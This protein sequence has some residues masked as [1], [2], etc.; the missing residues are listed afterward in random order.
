MKKSAPSIAA[1]LI[2]RDEA[3]SIVRCLESVRS[4]VDHIVV[5][6]TGSQDDTVDLARGC[7]AQLY[8]LDWPDN[9]SIARNHAL[10]LADAD[11]NLIID[12]D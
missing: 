1:A 9:F 3:R 10:D 7:G 12:A 11:W 2:V 5:L 6:D 4:W 8:Q